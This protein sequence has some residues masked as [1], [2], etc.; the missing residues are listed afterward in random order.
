MPTSGL[1]NSNAMQPGLIP[2]TSKSK[3]APSASKIAKHLIINQKQLLIF[4]VICI[5]WPPFYE[6][7]T[8]PEHS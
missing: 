8:L 1:S 5:K 7:V 4:Y 6:N 2:I 3:S